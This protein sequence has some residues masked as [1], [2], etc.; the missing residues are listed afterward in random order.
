MFECDPSAGDWARLHQYV[1]W[2]RTLHPCLAPAT[3][4]VDACPSPTLIQPAWWAIF[5]QVGIIK[6]GPLR[7]SLPH[8]SSTSLSPP[9]ATH[10]PLHKS[11]QDSGASVDSRSS[12]LA[13]SP[14]I[15]VR[16]MRPRGSPSRR[17]SIF[18][19]LP[20]WFAAGK[21]R[22]LRASIRVSHQQHHAA[23]ESI[24]LDCHPGIPSCHSDGHFPIPRE[25]LALQTGGPTVT[26]PSRIG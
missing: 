19:R 20:S 14:R 21:F 26:A 13:D 9:F 23:S 1:S 25:H 11:V 7:H 3:P 2:V 15:F 5:P 8:L 12:P 4:P 16:H 10:H 24:P 18:L 22:Y 6:P 17:R